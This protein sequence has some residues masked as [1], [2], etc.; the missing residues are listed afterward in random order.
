MTI[1]G[2][3]SIVA[4]CRP[5]RIYQLTGYPRVRHRHGYPLALWFMNRRF[6]AAIEPALGTTLRFLLAGDAM[7]VI[8]SEAVALRE[9]EPRRHLRPHKFLDLLKGVGLVNIVFGYV[10]DERLGP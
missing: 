1:E 3:F 4:D 5:C 7:P 9:V 10:A 2:D 8:P 6:L